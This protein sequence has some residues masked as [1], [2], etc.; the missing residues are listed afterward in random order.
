MEACDVGLHSTRSRQQS[1]QLRFWLKFLVALS[2]HTD[3][4]EN[5]LRLKDVLDYFCDIFSSYPEDEQEGWKKIQV[6]YLSENMLI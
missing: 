5:I 3:G 1:V 4:Q 2:Y 6:N